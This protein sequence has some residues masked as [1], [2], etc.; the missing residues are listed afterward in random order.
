[1]EGTIPLRELKDDFYDYDQKTMSLVGRRSHKIITCGAE[2]DVVIAAVD[3][4]RNDVVFSLDRGVASIR[5]RAV[6]PRQAPARPAEGPAPVAIPGK[7]TVKAV[8]PVQT[9]APGKAVATT[10]ATVPVEPVEP[11]ED[12]EPAPPS[13]GRVG[14]RRPAIDPTVDR[15]RLPDRWR[16]GGSSEKSAKSSS[17]DKGGLGAGPFKKSGKTDRLKPS[18]QGKRKDRTEPAFRGGKPFAKGKAKGKRG[19]R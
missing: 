12:A 1:M 18:K 5:P 2:V 13:T 3:I 7:A 4:E 9:V 19:P 15:R 16:S 11:A 8:A 17:G 6:T 10:K 14:G